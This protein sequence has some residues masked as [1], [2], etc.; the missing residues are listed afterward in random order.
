[1]RRYAYLVALVALAGCSR[2]VNVDQ[3][4]A[5]LMEA[6][7]EWSQQTKDVERFVSY[8]AADATI[9][10]PGMPAI[11]GAEAIRKAWTEMSSA[12]GFALSWA[13]TKS[14]VAASGDVGYTTGTYEMSMAGAA[15][16]GKYV[17]VWKKEGDAWKVSE[18]IFNAD[19]APQGAP[20]QHVMLSPGE[21]KWGDPPP[22]L[23]PG[24]RIAVV[25]GDPTQAQ[26]FVLRAQVPAG[27][28]V[29]PHWHPGDE[30]LTVLS[31]TIAL[32]MGEKF[33]EAAMT[34]IAP[35]GYAALPAETR[36]YFLAKTRSTFQVHGMGPFVVNYVNVADD[37]SKQQQ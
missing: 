31:G 3:E 13:P 34:S 37:P 29:A 5:A 10:A 8:F 18:D 23:P 1:M 20:A 19:A 35:G 33:D 6:D 4:R 15:E 9:S 27:Y 28:R 32:G 11:T 24:S 14:V 2:P 30:H 22:S 12:P 17:T 25:S 26:P 36:H 16:K 21:L 7:R